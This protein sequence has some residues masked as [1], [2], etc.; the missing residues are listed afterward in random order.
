MMKFGNKLIVAALCFGSIGLIDVAVAPDTV[1]AEKLFFE[2]DMVRGRPKT[3]PTGP[4]CVLTS[5][6][7]RKEKVV[8]R[9][10]I[11]DPAKAKPLGKAALKS[12]VVE[13]S[14]GQKFP[15]HHGNHPPKKSTDSFWAVSWDIP[16]DY[17]TGSFSYKVVATDSDGK[18]H[19]W[20]PFNVRPSQFTV[21]AG[22]IK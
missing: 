10:R 13:L 16:A 5:Q 7:K 20:T 15:M 17:P 14:D 3:G 22:N 1:A 8:W 21:I 11:H 19:T 6:F 18:A 12:V 9:V 2:G 4:V